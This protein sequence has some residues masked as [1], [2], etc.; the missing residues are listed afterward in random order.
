MPL[1]SLSR[2]CRNADMQGAALCSASARKCH[3]DMPALTIR[4]RIPPASTL[5]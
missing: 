5:N 3:T 4:S 2:S 1:T